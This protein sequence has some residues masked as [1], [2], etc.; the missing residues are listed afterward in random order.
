MCDFDKTK[1]TAIQAAMLSSAFRGG[2]LTGA[3]ALALGLARIVDR[4]LLSQP[5]ISGSPC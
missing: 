3:V 1:T 4:D 5:D 2:V